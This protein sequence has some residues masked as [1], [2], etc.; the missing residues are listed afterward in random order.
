MQKVNSGTAY[1]IW[2]L[3]FFGICGGQRLYTGNIVS[4]LI[5]LFTFGIFGIG[6]FL[7]LILIP[8]MV[9]KRNIY[10]RG[11][12]VGEASGSN[13]AIT[14]NIDDLK[15]FKQAQ[16]SFS[17][18]PMQKLLKAAKDHGGT[19]SIAQAVLYTELDPQD[20]QELLIDAQRH[21]LAEITNDPET[22]AIRYRFDL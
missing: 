21:H 4:G 7:D 20:V 14:L 13:P 12:G 3:C 22:G 19:L 9:N 11:L 6:Q 16:P 18:T 5:Y 10:L 8:G 1:I 15:Q 17:K 2:G